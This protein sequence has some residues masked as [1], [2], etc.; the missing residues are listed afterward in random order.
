M[1]KW[2]DEVLVG[3]AVYNVA[4]NV[5]LN[6]VR[7][8]LANEVLGEGTRFCAGNMGR[9]MQKSLMGRL[10]CYDGEDVAVSDFPVADNGLSQGV[11]LV[12]LFVGMELAAEG[13][14]Y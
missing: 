2:V 8:G 7:F 1:V 12:R 4:G 14:D 5:N 13:L 6:G 3:E 11:F 10:F 9:M